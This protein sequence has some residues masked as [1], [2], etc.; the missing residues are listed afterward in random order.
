[1]KQIDR[2]T[3]DPNFMGGKA[4]MRGMRVTV[5][6][7]V[8]PYRPRSACRGA[9][10]EQI[11]RS[12]NI[13]AASGPIEALLRERI[14]D[15]KSAV[16]AIDELTTAARRAAAS[17][18]SPAGTRPGRNRVVRRLPNGASSLFPEAWRRLLEPIPARERGE[19]ERAS[20]YGSLGQR[21]TGTW[22]LRPAGTTTSKPE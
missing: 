13:S 5:G 1:M 22:R 10:P 3:H 11:C 20:R 18:A 2:I 6:A 12:S 9:L 19:I 15:A 21:E 17:A 4:G 16:S 7:I 8:G 14:G